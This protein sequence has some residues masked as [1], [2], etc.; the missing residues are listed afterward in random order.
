MTYLLFSLFSV[1]AIKF[2]HTTCRVYKSLVTCIKRMT[3][4]TNFYMH[5]FQSGPCGHFMPAGTPN[6]CFIIFW[7]NFS[8][9]N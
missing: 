5:F 7:V 3:C 6:R 8:F 2:F 4:G 9:H 1:S